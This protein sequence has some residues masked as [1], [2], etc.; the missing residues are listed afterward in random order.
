M[1]VE[2]SICLKSAQWEELEP[3]LPLGMCTKLGRDEGFPM[4]DCRIIVNEAEYRTLLETAR[5]HCPSLVTLI[6][7]QKQLSSRS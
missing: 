7:K 3:H 6:E 4:L 2:M 1:V 5:K